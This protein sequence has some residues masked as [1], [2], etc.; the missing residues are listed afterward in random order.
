MISST[1]HPRNIRELGNQISKKSTSTPYEVVEV[2]SKA[3]KKSLTDKFDAFLRKGHFTV[4][5]VGEPK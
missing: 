3:D 2:F 1:S 4:V 5:F